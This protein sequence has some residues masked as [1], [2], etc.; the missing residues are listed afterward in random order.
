MLISNKFYD[1]LRKITLILPIIA[2]LYIMLSEI[3][4]FVY[5]D[6]ILRTFVAI[7]GALNTFLEVSNRKYKKSKAQDTSKG[8]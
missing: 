7:D 8:E 5:V 1:I 4:G 2:T 3:W 6:K